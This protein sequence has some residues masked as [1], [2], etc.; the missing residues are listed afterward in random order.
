M[1]LMNEMLPFPWRQLQVKLKITLFVRELKHD[2][3]TNASSPFAGE[4]ALS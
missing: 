3:R 2:P 4:L 1:Y